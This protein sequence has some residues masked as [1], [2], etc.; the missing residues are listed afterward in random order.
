MESAG[1]RLR[2]LGLLVQ[3]LVGGG[4][5]VTAICVTGV[6]ECSRFY[7]TL[8]VECVLSTHCKII[9]LYP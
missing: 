5:L 7:K 8:I 3:R 9:F 1:R 4:P 6:V 2:A